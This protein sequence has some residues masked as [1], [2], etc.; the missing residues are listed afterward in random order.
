MIDIARPVATKEKIKVRH[1][2]DVKISDLKRDIAMS[3]L[4]TNPRRMLIC[5]PLNMIVLCLVLWTTML[6]RNLALVFCDLAARGIPMIY[7]PKSKNYGAVN[8]D[9]YHLRGSQAGI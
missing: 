9:G 2:R 5:W 3:P 8:V 7:E 6:L 1:L 4:I